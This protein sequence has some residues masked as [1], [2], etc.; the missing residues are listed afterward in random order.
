MRLAAVKAWAI[1]VEA[2]VEAWA[3]AVEAPV[4]E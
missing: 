2:A 4:F 1:A 3:I